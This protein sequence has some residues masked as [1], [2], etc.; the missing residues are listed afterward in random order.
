[1]F[2]YDKMIGV[3]LIS[4]LKE[5][6]KEIIFITCRVHPGETPASFVL[7]GFLNTLYQKFKLIKNYV[8]VVVPCVNP[9]G[10]Q[11][12]HFRYDSLG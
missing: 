3:D 10:V 11:L 4:N 5:I 6:D 2:S 7:D 9:D 12:G 8:V 1:M